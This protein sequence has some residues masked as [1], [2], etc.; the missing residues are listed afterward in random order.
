MSEAK[1]ATNSHQRASTERRKVLE[2]ARNLEKKGYKVK[3]SLGSRPRPEKIGQWEP[4]IVAVDP[5]GR[6]I[7]IEVKMPSSISEH[8]ERLKEFARYARQ[9]PDADFRLYVTIPRGKQKRAANA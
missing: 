6:R 4:D 2:I 8:M 3:S 9:S 7:I 1:S 5:L